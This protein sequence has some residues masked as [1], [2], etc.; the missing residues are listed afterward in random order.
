MFFLMKKYID[1][2]DPANIANLASLLWQE[3]LKKI[4]SVYS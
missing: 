2:K 1:S 3:Q 4:S